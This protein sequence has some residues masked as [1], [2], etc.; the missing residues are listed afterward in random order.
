MFGAVGTPEFDSL[1]FERLIEFW[2]VV[3]GAISTE[4]VNDK[5]F[6][7]LIRVYELPLASLESE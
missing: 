3:V 1:A 4:I 2:R 7:T 6:I 5:P